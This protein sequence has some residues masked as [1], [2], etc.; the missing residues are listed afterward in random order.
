LLCASS[1]SERS[2]KV[3]K[4]LL[5]AG[6]D[7]NA[8]FYLPL[9]FPSKHSTWITLP[10]QGNFKRREDIIRRFLASGARLRELTVIQYDISKEGWGRTKRFSLPSA[11]SATTNILVELNAVC[12]LR[13]Y[14]ECTKEQAC[15]LQHPTVL[16]VPT[17]R[18]VLL[19]RPSSERQRATLTSVE[20]S[21]TLLAMMDELLPPWEG[22]FGP[23]L[24]NA[25]SGDKK[26]KTRSIANT[27]I[28]KIEELHERSDKVD[29]L[30]FLERKGY[31]NTRIT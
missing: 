2:V 21:K 7:P 14:L 18:R 10:S 24:S 12:L 29:L 9:R 8:T 6:A 1:F 27:I 17:H 28:K 25:S 30:E 22:I 19:I 20:D 31:T 5:E 15:L 4:H 11:F 26:G 13:D 3:L 23:R 16:E